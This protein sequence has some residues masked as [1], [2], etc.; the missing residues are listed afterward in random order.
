MTTLGIV[1]GKRKSESDYD[2]FKNLRLFIRWKFSLLFFS[3]IISTVV[4][5]YNS[6]DKKNRFSNSEFATAIFDIE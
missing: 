3:S 1:N 5:Y 2:T 6:F 4:H